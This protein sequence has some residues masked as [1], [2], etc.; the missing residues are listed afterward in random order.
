MPESLPGCRSE[1]T[2]RCVRTCSVTWRVPFQD[3]RRE[4]EEVL[5]KDLAAAC[6][7]V[8][9]SGIYVLGPEVQAFEREFAVAV[10]RRHAI[11]V[12]SGLDAIVIALRALGVGAGDEVVTTPL[13]AAATALA[14]THVGATPVFADVN[15]DTLTLDPRQVERALSARTKV[16]LPVHLYGAPAEDEAL[17]LLC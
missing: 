15:D 10:G 1:W 5:Q 3:F 16:V 17:L 14:V 8:F 11:G 6:D 12:A 4:Y 7:R 13:S 9:R 2:C